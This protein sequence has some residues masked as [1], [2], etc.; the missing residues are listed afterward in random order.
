MRQGLG[1]ALPSGLSPDDLRV[2]YRACTYTS[3]PEN[4]IVQ[5]SCFS[6]TEKDEPQLRINRLDSQQS[7]AINRRIQFAIIDELYRQQA[8]GALMKIAESSVVPA[9]VRQVSYMA[10]VAGIAQSGDRGEATTLIPDLRVDLLSLKAIVPYMIVLAECGVDI[11]GLGKGGD[12]PDIPDVLFGPR[13]MELNEEI[14]EIY[15]RL[16]LFCLADPNAIPWLEARLSGMPRAIAALL[17]AFGKLAKL[18]SDWVAARQGTNS[19]QPCDFSEIAGAILHVR[20]Y[21]KDPGENDYLYSRELPKFLQYVWDGVAKALAGDRLTEFVRLWIEIHA[22]SAT[23][24][25]PEATRNLAICLSPSLGPKSAAVDD[26]LRMAERASRAEEETSVIASEL[27]A[28]A[29]AWGRCGFLDDA[30]RIWGELLDVAC[31]VYWRKDYQFNEVLKSMELAHSQ[32]PG[33]SLNRVSEQ[34]V[35]AHQL[36]DAARSKTV[37]VAIEELIA[38]SAKISPSLSLQMLWKEDDS[39]FRERAIRDLLPKLLVDDSIDPYLLWSLASTMNIWEDYQAFRDETLPALRSIYESSVQRHLLPTTETIYRH[40]RHLLLVQKNMASE[41]GIWADIWVGAGD[42]PAQVRADRDRYMVASEERKPEETVEFLAEP[43]T[44]KLDEAAGRGITDLDREMDALEQDI[45]R[46]ER[47]RELDNLKNEWERLFQSTLGRKSTVDEER[48]FDVG[49]QRFEERLVNITR[50]DRFTTEQQVRQAL[51]EFVSDFRSQL[52]TTADLQ[53][54]VSAFDVDAWLKRF[55]HNGPPRYSMGRVLEK[56]LP[57]WI[58]AARYTDLP[59]WVEVCRRRCWGEIK[60]KALYMIGMR[61]KS[62][63]RPGAMCLLIEAWESSAEFFFMHTQLARSICSDAI[64]LDKDRGIK[65]LFDSFREYHQRYPQSIVHNLDEVLRFS[66]QFPATDF[67]QLYAVWSDY[68]RNL[69]AGLS[70]KPVDIAWIRDDL[71]AAFSE[72]CITY[73]VRLLDYAEIDIRILAENACYGL[74]IENTAA[75]SSLISLWPGLNATQ[76]EHLILLL[77]SYA[78]A[79]PEKVQEWCP[80]LLAFVNE[81]TQFNVCQTASELV[82]AVESVGTV[83]SQSIHDQAKR[84]TERQSVT[85]PST[86]DVQIPQNRGIPCLL[87]TRFL[88]DKLKEI[89][90]SESVDVRLLSFVLRH[91]GDPR[92]GFAEE[93]ATHRAHNINTNF[94]SIEISGRYDQTVR[95]GIND[96]LD[97]FVRSNRVERK[98]AL[99]YSPLLR[100]EDPTDRLV[101]TTE[102]PANIDWLDSRLSAE[103]FVNYADWDKLLFRV[104]SLATGWITLFEETEQRTGDRTSSEPS[105]ASKVYWSLFYAPESEMRIGL[106]DLDNA[107][108]ISRNQYR[109]ELRSA[110]CRKSR[111]NTADETASLVQLSVRNFRGRV[112]PSTAALRPTIAKE[113]GLQLSDTDLFGYERNGN[114]MVRSTEWQEAFDQGRRRH[115]PLSS[116]FLLEIEQEALRDWIIGNG[117]SLWAEL[118]IERTADRYKPEN[119]M[120]WTSR[121][122]RLEITLT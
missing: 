13:G 118:H 48:A 70:V 52:N 71:P 17:L 36:T 99:R 84:L 18:W 29:S 108:P 54:F 2:Y 28:T 49:F 106:D 73:L 38:F 15:D 64:S 37:E 90:P 91:Y 72:S 96:I 80:A 50:A 57:Q 92:T 75:P 51:G 58:A 94:D 110:V 102:K 83:L 100:V 22:G 59:E 24:P 121:T 97:G 55:L 5:V 46:Q 95:A 88:I 27:L 115:E 4:L 9:D 41:L 103:E 111:F 79:R 81:E 89:V 78:L 66:D 43:D 61:M 33:G 77:F 116:G 30:Q 112:R 31:G 16:R 63:D 60:G 12:K 34:L 85:V 19:P 6:W 76:K 45:F 40:A 10:A 86:A 47:R 1:E 104:G 93:G 119:E 120:N 82:S 3:D 44:A 114:A 53:D 87:Y 69:T 8:N 113:M 7:S 11:S 14:F 67:L 35:L 39:V 65:L 107:Q 21:L 26:L 62:V 98:K 25:P 56:R 68:N 23:P 122:G 74:L 20:Q 117:F 101:V 109:F 32:D 105:R 42:A